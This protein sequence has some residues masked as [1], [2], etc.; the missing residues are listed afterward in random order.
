L[1]ILFPLVTNF[2]TSM[3]PTIFD[4]KIFSRIFMDVIGYGTVFMDRIRDRQW[5]GL[6]YDNEDGDAFYCPDLVTQF[7]TYIDISTIGHDLHTSIVH[8]DS[9]DLVINVNTIEDITQISCPPQHVASLP[10]IDYISVMGV[11]CQEKDRRLKASTTFRIVHCVGRWV[12]HILGLDHTT[13]FNRPVLQIVHSLMIR[14]HTVCLNTVLW[15]HLVANFQRTRGAKYPHPVLVTRLYRHLL[16]D[17]VFSSFD[18][19]FIFTETS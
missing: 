19:V 17:E 5:Y 2:S 16:P 6:V 8:F 14:Q 13:L 4:E 18:Q 3:A 12:Q 11:R 15:Q 10:L 7:Y 9:G 1:Q